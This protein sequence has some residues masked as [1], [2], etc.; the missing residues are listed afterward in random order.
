MILRRLHAF[1]NRKRPDHLFPGLTRGRA[2]ELRSELRHTLAEKGATVRF[3]GR[4]AII[5]HPRRGRVTVN[6]ENLIGDVAASQHPKAAHT[7][8]RAFVTSILD[9]EHAEDLGTADLYAGLRLRIVSTKNLVPEEADI[10]AAA[11]L[12]EFTVDTA[13]TLVL[14]TERSIQTMPL[15]RLREVDS[16]D[17]LVRAARNNLREE[18]LGARVHAQTH[19]GSEERPGAYFRSFESGSYYV[20]SAP[21]LLEEVLY[22]WAPDLDQSRGVLFAIPARHVLLV[23]EISTGEDLLEGI[24]RLAPVAA[25]LAVDGTHTVSPLLHMWHEGE[26][27]TLSS[28]DPQAKELKITPTPYLLDLIARG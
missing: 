25:Q 27:T 17:T 14:D 4:H 26:V 9:G 6:L 28:F 1:R 15:E 11:T 12:H 21:L 2:G 5:E 8:A 16:L 23:R 24:G 19:P 18:L 22:A 3:D 10:V 7:M 13:V 20:A